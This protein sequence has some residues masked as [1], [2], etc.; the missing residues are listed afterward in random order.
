MIGRELSLIN[1]ENENFPRY[2]I[3]TEIQPAIRRFILGHFQQKLMTQFSAKV[4]KPYSCPFLGPFCPK[5]RERE[6]SEIWD[7]YRNH[8]TLHFRSFLAKTNDSIFRKSP[9]TLFWAFILP[10]FAPIFRGEGVEIEKKNLKVHFTR[11][12]Y[13]KS[14]FQNLQQLCWILAFCVK[15]KNPIFALFGPFL[16]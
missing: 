9:I 8:K 15:S 16:P 5:S 1:L 3:C 12:S 11:Q 7:L 2:G 4:Q 14:D 6:F 10:N 13:M